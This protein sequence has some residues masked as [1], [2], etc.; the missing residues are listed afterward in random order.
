MEIPI[1]FT[2]IT[3]WSGIFTLFCLLM[4]LLGLIFRWGI[5]FRLIG[6]TGFMAVLTV[7]LFGLSLGLFTRTIL[8]GA[9]RFAVVYDNG[10]NNAVI[11][12]QPTVTPDQIEATLRQAAND[13]Y[14]YG[15]IGIGGDNQLTVRVRT[16]IHPEPGLT[17]PVYLGEVHRALSS[18]DDDTIDIQV[19]SDRF[20]EL[21]TQN[22]A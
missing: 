1:D 6:I 18:R 12:V 17:K 21:P 10:A 16:L 13:L 4:A 8:P 22:N 5:R 3:Q 11:T 2:Q 20:A 9:V 14:S 7:G 19:F 15:R